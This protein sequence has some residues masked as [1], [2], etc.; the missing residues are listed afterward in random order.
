MKKEPVKKW[1][2]ANNKTV[3]IT[4]MRADEGGLRNRITCAVFNDKDLEKFH[5]LAPLSDEFINWFIQEQNIKL[6]ELYYPPF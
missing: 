3:T 5:P 4:G 1:A 6:C 2:L